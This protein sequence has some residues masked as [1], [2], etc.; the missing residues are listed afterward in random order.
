MLASLLMAAGL[1][2]SAPCG[3][4]G[5]PATFE[6]DNRVECGWV[7]VPRDTATSDGKRIRLWTARVKATGPAR[8]DPILYINGGPGIATVDSILPY[9]GEIKS[10]AAMRRDRD[11]IVFDQRG[12]GRSEEA[13]CPDLG[14]K[15]K[16]VADQGLSPEV[17]EQSARDLFVKCR[18]TLEQSGMSLESYTTR[19]TTA[20]LES[21]RKALGIERWNLLSVSYGS[22]VAMDAMRT[23]PESIRSVILNSP[24][25][26]N[27][28]NWAEQASVAAA[29][30]DAIDRSCDAQPKCRE[31]FGKL[32]PKLEET[33]ARLEAKPV[34]DGERKITGRLFAQA[35][36]PLAV[37]SATV[38]F[39]PL[40][41]ARA[42]SGDEEVIKGMAR[43]FAGG[44]AF[45]GY[46]PA[47]GVAIS[48]HEFGRSTAWY[49]R[50]R[51]LH[52]GLVSAAPDDSRDEMCAAYR[53]GYA[54]PEFFAPVASDIPTLL[55]AGA[56]DAAT[57]AVDAYQAMRF[58]TRATLVEV[59]GASHAPMGLDDCTSGIAVAFLDLPEV[60]PDL[61]CMDDRPPLEFAQD[62][63]TELF[64]PAKP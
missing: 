64:A 55:Y 25:P 56:L 23:Q 5:Q 6:R 7:S 2:Q 28:V 35:L 27:S 36:W 13:L 18:E 14:T 54:S 41:I 43:T 37:R 9:I 30:Y 8:P 49:A 24:Y 58:L 1:F 20:D 29:A 44:D 33:L 31:R 47:Q 21:L 42:H 50:A 60:A 39:V 48:C 17:E 19:A 15:L 57:P 62:G 11:I 12:S 51:S 46:S 34:V 38:R 10:L 45:G 16:A 63:L 22:L 59:E 61:K 52:P 32:V 3:L 53:P 26:P 4:E 40:A